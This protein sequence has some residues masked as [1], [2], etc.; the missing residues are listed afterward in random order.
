MRYWS[1][2]FSIEETHFCF[3]S[4]GRYPRLIFHSSERRE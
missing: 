2:F 4:L 3:K 1:R